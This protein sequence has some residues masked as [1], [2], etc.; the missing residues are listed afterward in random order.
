MDNLNTYIK[1][2]ESA[3]SNEEAYSTYNRDMFHAAVV[4]VAGIRHAK[5]EI[6]LLSNQLN[7]ALYGGHGLLNVARSFLQNEKAKLRVLVETDIS[8]D[9]PMMD[10][11]HEF[12]Q[13]VSI[14][15]VPDELQEKYDF[16]FLLIDDI[17]YRFEHDRKKYKAIASF[18][19][20]DRKENI[21]AMK[22][23]F[24]KLEK[25]CRV[26]LWPL[27]SDNVSP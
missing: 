21:D 9:H 24:N 11:C 23:H 19:K 17:G 3:L 26:I 27:K 20:P 1:R 8:Q 15:R 6:C 18:Y 5:N 14:S 16:N 13:K 10:L 2:L 4:V 25:Q 12:P 22:R 7:P